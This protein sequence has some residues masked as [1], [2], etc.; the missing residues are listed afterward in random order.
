MFNRTVVVLTCAGVCGGSNAA[1]AQDFNPSKPI[2]L[3][4]PFSPGGATD[5][6][7]RLLGTE[8]TKSLG[9]PV[10]IDNRPGAGGIIAAEL[11]A[12]SP[13]D[14]HTLL[15]SIRNRS[16]NLAQVSAVAG[17]PFLLVVHPSLPARTVKEFIALAR[18]RPN[19][20]NFGSS[21]LDSPS[22]H[23]MELFMSRT[24][25]KLVHVPYKG[26][27]PA[28]LDL[29]AGRIQAMFVTPSAALPHIKA[30][31]LRALG[32]TSTRRL[33]DAPDIPT[34]QEAGVP[35]LA[36]AVSYFLYAPAGTPK[37]V[38]DRLR[39]ETLRAVETPAN[40]AQL[41]SLGFA[42]RPQD[43]EGTPGSESC[44]AGQKWCA[45]QSK[46]IKDSETCP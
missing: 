19:E 5:I 38:L 30:G 45:S 16:K 6:L 11:A 34:L 24:G 40:R 28:L 17:Q 29:S 25:V 14:G 10:V 35:G 23:A 1:M 15:L 9:Q 7:A 27:A 18:M 44:P 32:V 20:L 39:A 46:C 37:P 21:G 2:R 36:Y 31:R 41:A 12:K 26:G 43:A 42:L 3:I 22:Q 4:V 33:E 13:S 8:F